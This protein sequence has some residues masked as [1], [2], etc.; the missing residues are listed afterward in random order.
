MTRLAELLPFNEGE[1]LMSYCSR[2]AAACG[3]ENAR[4]FT[5]R[6]GFTF[7]GLALG[8]EEAVARFASALGTSKT[9]LARGLVTR[10]DPFWT[11]SGERFSRAM[12]RRAHLRVCPHCVLED[13]H[14]AAGRRGFRAFGRIEWLAGPVSV[15][16]EHESSISTF[17]SDEPLQYLE[18]DFAGKLSF[19]N[20]EILALAGTKARF[21]PDAYQGYVEG[22]LRSGP[23]G[24]R[25][26]DRF[27]I[28]VV[29]RICE[30]VGLVEQF[31]I[32]VQYGKLEEL[33][34]A[35]SAA[36]GYDMI[37]AA[38]AN[39]Q[40][41]LERLAGRFQQT[42][43]DIKGKGLFGY[44]YH[45]LAAATPTEEYEPF[46]KVMREVTLNTIPL[47]KGAENLGPVTSR[48]LHS[49]HSAA[50]EYDLQPLRLRNLLI[51]SKKV[52]V[53]CARKSYHRIVLDV[54]EMEKFCLEVKQALSFKE[55]VAALGTERSQLASIVNFGILHRLEDA[56]AGVR[57][58]S[59]KVH[60]TATMCFRRADV[61]ELGRRLDSLPPCPPMEDCV[62][63]SQAA[64]MA[65]CKN[66]EVVRL[67]LDGELDIARIEGRSGLAA[68]A[69]N[70]F[71]VRKKTQGFIHSCL[72]LRDVELAISSSHKV[73]NAL[74][75]DGHLASVK[76]KN[77]WK[78]HLQTVVEP[79]EL[80]RFIEAFVSSGTLAY[81]NRKTPAGIERCLAEAGIFPE[82][83]ASKKKFYSVLDVKDFPFLP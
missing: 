45:V 82:F 56:V 1:S 43:S 49:V 60:V 51:L 32:N 38:E 14:A 55:A 71:E 41:F 26:L 73:V 62:N 12:V 59:K 61:E 33:Q 68:I 67:L 36:C 63:V 78:R 8:R 15:C 17:R 69:V 11:I 3:Y 54:D 72:T 25:W 76:R 5:T 30:A 83:I 23:K 79:D 6:L 40:A 35:T 29:G 81:R 31:G 28:H 37:H 2:L 10:A 19:F 4:V 21:K 42:D 16:R 80:T 34:V 65:N 52:G 58:P 57:D 77:P 74:I 44:M 70:P 9:S 66:G 48:R 53:E 24:D 27:P 75:E 18:N 39:F 20:K 46:R 47:G 7:S 22:R 64:K 50:L 13:E